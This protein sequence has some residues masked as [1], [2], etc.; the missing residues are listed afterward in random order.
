M[1][2]EKEPLIRVGIMTA[3]DIEVVYKGG[4]VPCFELKN[5]TI[6][7]QFHWQREESQVFSG[8]L[9]LLRNFNGTLTAVNIVPLEEYLRSVISSEMSA[10]S[11]PELL[12]A[13]SVISRSWLIAQKYGDIRCE[14]LKDYAS[15]SR[16]ESETQM[17]RWYDREDHDGFDVCA[18]DHCQRYQGLTRIISDNVSQSVEATRGEVLTFE[19]KVCDAR[20]S[21]CCGGV[22]EEFQSCWAPVRHGYLKAVSDIAEDRDILDMKNEKF[23]RLWIESNPECFCNTSDKHLLGQI[24]NSYDIEDLQFF[25][26][27][28]IYEEEELN[29]LVARK[30]GIDFGHIIKITPVKRG[31]SGRI[32]LLRIEG[33]KA[34]VDVGKELEIR[35]WLSPTHLKSSAFIIDRD[36]ERRWILTGAGWGH[37]VGLCQIGAAV[38]ASKGYGYREILAHY[39]PGTLVEKLY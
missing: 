35:R 33:S 18:D 3:P 39:F 20:F 22:T 28:E 14:G 38:M 6:G 31:P 32:T 12:K 37:G 4:K 16:I 13:H 21:K 27:K 24:L 17:V 19:K 2:L 8:E 1:K 29:A 10:T 11:S 15:H 30:S 26:W 5:V 34:I 9:E 7:K 25:R 23:V 36:D